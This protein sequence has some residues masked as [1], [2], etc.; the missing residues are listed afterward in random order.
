M[1]ISRKLTNRLPNDEDFPNAERLDSLVRE[2][3]SLLSIR[4]SSDPELE[5]RLRMLA[6]SLV[7]NYAIQHHESF[8]ITAK[9]LL[10]GIRRET[11]AK[12]EKRIASQI[13]RTSE[14]LYE[15]L[16]DGP[17]MPRQQI[18]TEIGLW[19]EDKINQIANDPY[20]GKNF[21]LDIA[22]HCIYQFSQIAKDYNKIPVI[23]T[24]YTPEYA[25]IRD[26]VGI[27]TDYKKSKEI[28]KQIAGL[29]FQ[30]VTGHLPKEQSWGDYHKKRVRKDD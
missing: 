20:K 28:G 3:L 13:Q 17:E 15:L 19:I 27:A 18:L 8:H 6:W 12:Q 4:S 30:A 21:G 11:N 5:I 9:R 24:E 14:K 29:A 22:I 16:C 10:A 25:L 7:D 2:S 1:A 26:A 23:K